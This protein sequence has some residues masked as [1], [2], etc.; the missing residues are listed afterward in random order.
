MNRAQRP[1]DK[2]NGRGTAKEDSP[3]GAFKAFSCTVRPH[4]PNAKI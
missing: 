2:K 4:K 1:N 3:G